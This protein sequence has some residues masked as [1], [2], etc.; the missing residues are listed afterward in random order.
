MRSPPRLPESAPGRPDWSRAT[1]MCTSVEEWR[2]AQLSLGLRE[3]PSRATRVSPCSR[4]FR[5]HVITHRGRGKNRIPV[6]S[7]H[8][9]RPKAPNTPP[10]ISA[11]GD[12]K[13]APSS[14]LFGSRRG[15]HSSVKHIR[16]LSLKQ[17]TA[18]RPVFTFLVM[19]KCIFVNRFTHGLLS[20]VLNMG[21]LD[22]TFEF[23][24]FC[25][26]C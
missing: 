22:L 20:W 14:C 8:T 18:K 13:L 1:R 15:G 2:T 5:A 21:S 19:H 4:R 17:P 23:G 24:F 12:C 26:C 3:T 16:A 7:P 6:S 11:C 9:S 25:C 10:R